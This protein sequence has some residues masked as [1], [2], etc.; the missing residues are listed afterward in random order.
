MKRPV[1]LVLMSTYN[2]ERFLKEQIDSIL[3]QEGVDVRLLVR[4][5]GSKD[6]TQTFLSDYAS[7][8]QN[9]SWKACDNVGFVKSF[10]ALVS[11]ALASDSPADFY[12]FADQDDIW[13]PHKLATACSVLSMKD[14]AKPHLFTSNS[15]QIDA[16]GH[17]LDLFHKGP[18]P[19]FRKGNVLVF[20]TEQGCSMVFNRKA[21]ELYA[22]CEPKLTWHDRW[23]YHI[24]YFLGCVTYDHR[25]LFYYR[26]HENNALANH[27]A[28]SLE[29]ERSKIIRVYR[30][31]FVE[32]PVTNHVEMAQ[33]FYDHFGSRLN[34]ADRRLFR[35][36][37]R[38]RK[39]VVSKIYMLFSRHFIYPYYDANEGRLLKWLIMAG[40]L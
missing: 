26:R 33:E 20:G 24:C 27:H 8:H 39:S 25:P 4:D 37:V 36:F 34:E 9:I 16:E 21:M 13:M 30:I 28:G 32:P 7:K 11:M 15:M 35:R 10:S 12:A 6:Q 2:G 3:S 38:C 14:N 17:E 29:G 18:E 1:V 40:R 23:M 5:D 31:L 19:K 22:E